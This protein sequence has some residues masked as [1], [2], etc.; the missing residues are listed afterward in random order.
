MTHSGGVLVLWFSQGGSEDDLLD[1]IKNNKVSRALFL[2]QK[3]LVVHGDMEPNRTDKTK[4]LLEVTTLNAFM[5][6]T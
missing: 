2:T 3:A 5:Y 6:L 4:G 1:R